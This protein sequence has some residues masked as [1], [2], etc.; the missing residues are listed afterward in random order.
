MAAVSNLFLSPLEQNPIFE[1]GTY[2]H[3]KEYRKAIPIMPL[4]LEL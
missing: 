1:N 2:L 3:V 4:G